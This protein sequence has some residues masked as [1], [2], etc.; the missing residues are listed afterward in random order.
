MK[1]LLAALC[2]SWAALAG[3]AP[4][5]ATGTVEVLF[6]PWDD[7]EGAII[8]VLGEARQS[9]H[10]QAYLLTSR[11]I[12]KALL[13]AQARGVKVEVLADSEMIRKG[14]NS[15]IPKLAAGGIPVWRETRYASAH[16]KV[17]LIDA[18]AEN[19]TVIT[20]SYNYTWSAQARNAEN[21]LILRDN[22]TLLRQYLDNWQRHRDGSERMSGTN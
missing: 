22:P 19:G 14:D 11:P 12:A 18:L 7:A 3:A 4:Q 1:Q 9:I 13:D 2:L 20:G 6:T 17:I 21:L 8:R 16:N 5:A 15:Q 10:V